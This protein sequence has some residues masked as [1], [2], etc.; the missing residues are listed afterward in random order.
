M[1]WGI[2]GTGGVAQAFAEAL[3]D[4]PDAQLAAVGS[5]SL[6]RAE[7]F[8]ERH[9]VVHVH[10]SYEGLADCDAGLDA[11]Y[12]ATPASHHYVHTML[13]LRA[14][15]HV[16]CEKPFAVNREQTSLMFSEAHNRGLLLMEAMWPRFLPSWATIRELSWKIGDIRAIEA[17]FGG[18]ADFQ[19]SKRPFRNDLGGGSL[20]DAAV[21]PISF[22]EM[23]LGP[24]SEVHAAALIGPSGVDDQVSVM[25]RTVTG[26][27]ITCLAGITTTFK[28][29]ATIYGTE[30]MIVVPGNFTN[31]PWV[32][33]HRVGKEPQHYDFGPSARHRLAW[34]AI[35]FQN[36]VASGDTEA[37]VMPRASTCE[38][39]RV[40][41][42]ARAQIGLPPVP[43]VQ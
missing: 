23:I 20:L 17:S 4:V 21:Y 32:E 33:L 34:Q 7:L 36:H 1:R 39:M 40:L 15:K 29:D 2:M 41:D 18:R 31:P 13:A 11:I 12:V 38:V 26:A 37:A 8:A 19:P 43:E 22:A 28:A 24:F 27:L 5:R 16:L 25:L 9:S 42:E 35:E 6:V 3:R 30:G 10:Q 14:G